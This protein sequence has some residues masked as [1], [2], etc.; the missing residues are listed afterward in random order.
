MYTH[1]KR[2]HTHFKAPVVHVKSS[3]DYGNAQ[4]TQQELKVTESSVLKPLDTIPTKEEGGGELA[5]S[6]CTE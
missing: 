3:L 6:A 2:S 4:I 1:V 5:N